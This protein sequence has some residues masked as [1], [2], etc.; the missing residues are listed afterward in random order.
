M[1]AVEKRLNP[2]SLPS[3]EASIKPPPLVLGNISLEELLRL[4]PRSTEA[5]AKSNGDLN[6]LYGFIPYSS[7]PALLNKLQEWLKN[8]SVESKIVDDSC[9]NWTLPDDREEF[10]ANLALQIAHLIECPRR[11]AESSSDTLEK[12]QQSVMM[13]YNTIFY[14]LEHSIEDWFYIRNNRNISVKKYIAEKYRTANDNQKQAFIRL[15]ESVKQVVDE[16][17]FLKCFMDFLSFFQFKVDQNSLFTEDELKVLLNIETLRPKIKKIIEQRVAI[18]TEEKQEEVEEYSDILVTVQTCFEEAKRVTFNI[19]IGKIIVKKENGKITEVQIWDY[20]SDG[21]TEETITEKTLL[22]IVLKMLLGNLAA[23]LAKPAEDY[24]GFRRYFIKINLEKLARK[25]YS[26]KFFV[27]EV[28]IYGGKV[29]EITITSYDFAKAIELIKKYFSK[30]IGHRKALIRKNNNPTLGFWAPRRSKTRIEPEQTDTPDDTATTDFSDASIPT[31]SGEEERNETFDA[32]PTIVFRNGEGILQIYID[33]KMQLIN[34][35]PAVQITDINREPHW[36]TKGALIRK[37]ELHEN[38]NIFFGEY[39][40]LFFL[41]IRENNNF[42]IIVIDKLPKYV[43]FG[44]DG[45]LFVYLKGGELL[46]FNHFIPSNSTI[47]Y[48]TSLQLNYILPAPVKEEDGFIYVKHQNGYSYPLYKS[49][50]GYYI[51]VG[52]NCYCH[53]NFDGTGN[54]IISEGYTSLENLNSAVMPDDWLKIFQSASATSI[55]IEM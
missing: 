14:F 42:K 17:E 23:R 22:E 34:L 28:G 30:L 39:K 21:L 27:K 50:K 32:S 29:T 31:E 20:R 2:F 6:D 11:R 43:H 45:L 10:V 3:S 9:A 52:F 35:K 15:L 47:Q 41:I 19:K 37:D 55:N 51:I 26:V 13:W 1:G 38:E 46:G 36:V 16:A 48:F 44:V 33:G 18:E 49:P 24:D 7:V 25:T 5:I 8:F 53:V 4:I 40:T 54:P 12:L